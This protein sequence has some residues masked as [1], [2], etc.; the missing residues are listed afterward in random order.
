MKK[1]LLIWF[2]VIS[3]FA[4]GWFFYKWQLIEHIYVDR[5][6]SNFEQ[7]TR[8]ASF[9]IGL[10]PAQ[11]SADPTYVGLKLQA[12]SNAFASASNMYHPD[13]EVPVDETDFKY[14]WGFHLILERE[15]LP[16]IEKLEYTDQSLS[17]EDEEK[18]MQL[19]SNLLDSGLIGEYEHTKESDL[20]IHA[21][22][23][24]LRL[25]GALSTKGNLR[26]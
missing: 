6:V 23:G 20:Y 7:T 11:I 17:E 12:A 16:I 25:E 2:L 1:K 9:M 4:N 22:K 5:L 18:L 10:S 13:I 19:T 21:V 3:L 8:Y 24:F 26:L 14:L 15:Y